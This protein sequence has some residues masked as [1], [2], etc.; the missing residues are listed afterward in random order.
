M[1]TKIWT[2]DEIQSAMLAAGSHWWDHT[3]MRM[4]GTRLCGPVFCGPDGI[5]FATSEHNFDKT[6]RLYTVRRF[7]PDS[8]AISTVG[9]MGDYRSAAAAAKAAR[10]LSGNGSFRCADYH[11]LGQDEQL[12]HDLAQHGCSGVTLCKCRELM[13]LAKR[14]RRIMEDYCNGVEVYDKDGE[15]LPRLARLLGRLAAAAA[16][17]GCVGVVTSG[18]PRGATV[19]LTLPDGFTNDWGHDGFVVPFVD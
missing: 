3:T 18:D 10:R 4:F 9:E 2:H 15:P 14:H 1:E 19:K 17:V 11:P 12:A 13:K 7:D 6:A 8:L 16:A 5:Y